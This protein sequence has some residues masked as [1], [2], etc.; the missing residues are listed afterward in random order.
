[1]NKFIAENT[2]TSL[3]DHEIIIKNIGNNIFT[4]IV[5]DKETGA[6]KNVILIKKL[7]I[8]L[9]NRS[10]ISQMSLPMHDPDSPF[11]YIRDNK[12]RKIQ[13]RTYI[14]EDGD[15][16]WSTDYRETTHMEQIAWRKVNSL[17]NNKIIQNVAEKTYKELLD[18]YDTINK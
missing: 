18:S 17:F 6:T 3:L 2:E 7:D 9:S 10:K 8:I 1:M 14:D 11:M 16:F 15:I 5:V 12:N 13:L 4:R